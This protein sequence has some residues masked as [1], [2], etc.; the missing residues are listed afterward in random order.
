MVKHFNIDEMDFTYDKRKPI[1][2]RKDIDEKFRRKRLKYP[3]GERLQLDVNLFVES[4]DRLN[5]K[6]ESIFYRH[7]VIQTFDGYGHCERLRWKGLDGYVKEHNYSYLVFIFDRYF[8]KGW[9][10]LCRSWKHTSKHDVSSM[11]YYKFYQTYK[12]YMSNILKW[13]KIM[14]INRDD[15]KQFKRC[16]E[17]LRALDRCDW[18]IEANGED[19]LL[20]EEAICKYHYPLKL[21]VKK[22]IAQMFNSNVFDEGRSVPFFGPIDEVEKPERGWRVD[23]RPK[24]NK[25]FS[26]YDLFPTF[27]RL[28]ARVQ[29]EIWIVLAYINELHN[30]L[31]RDYLVG[32]IKKYYE[33][34]ILDPL[35]CLKAYNNHYVSTEHRGTNYSGKAQMFSGIWPS[36]FGPGDEDDLPII[37]EVG[38]MD[39]IKSVPA[40]VEEVKLVRQLAEEQVPKAVDQANRVN[41]FLDTVKS[42]FSKFSWSSVSEFISSG[43]DA[44]KNFCSEAFNK[45]KELCNK[46][47]NIIS[48]SWLAK[49][50]V[51]FGFGLLIAF[52][53]QKFASLTIDM[54]NMLDL[55]CEEWFGMPTCLE[56][57]AES[58]MVGTG[59]LVC[60]ILA[61]ISMVACGCRMPTDRLATS[62]MSH[63]NLVSAVSDA[64][65]A[66]INWICKKVLNI[67]YF[68][69]PEEI[70]EIT[71]WLHD[72]EEIFSIPNID[73]KVCTDKDIARKVIELQL[74]LKGWNQFLMNP[75]FSTYFN[76][77]A[78]AHKVIK[79]KLL[80]DKATV[81]CSGA[82]TRPVPTMIYLGGEG[83][84]GKSVL[85]NILLSYA[86]HRIAK[87]Y[88][89]D[90]PDN[91]DGP[92]LMK[93]VD[94]NY[95][96][97][98]PEDIYPRD[99]SGEVVYWENYH[100]QRVIMYNDIFKVAEQPK[101]AVIASELMAVTESTAY[102][103]NM[104]FERKGLVYCDSEWVLATSNFLDANN[105][106][107]TD[108][109]VGGFVRRVQFPL[110]VHRVENLKKDNSNLKTAWVFEVI[111]LAQKASGET[112]R[113]I[114]MALDE[115]GLKLGQKLNFFEVV[116]LMVECHRKHKAGEGIIKFE[117]F[118]WDAVDAAQAQMFKAKE[119]K[120]ARKKISINSYLGYL[121]FK[122]N[123]EAVKN[124]SIIP[125]LPIFQSVCSEFDPTLVTHPPSSDDFELLRLNYDEVYNAQVDLTIGN[126][127]NCNEYEIAVSILQG[128]VVCGKIDTFALSDFDGNVLCHAILNKIRDN[129]DRS[130]LFYNGLAFR[131]VNYRELG[132][133]LKGE[134][135][136]DFDKMGLIPYVDSYVKCVLVRCNGSL[137]RDSSLVID[138]GHT[139]FIKGNVNEDGEVIPYNRMEYLNNRYE[140]I[141]PVVT[142]EQSFI[143]GKTEVQYAPGRVLSET[144][145]SFRSFRDGLARYINDAWSYLTSIDLSKPFEADSVY[146]KVLKGA[147]GLAVITTLVGLI[148]YS[149]K[150]VYEKFFQ[151]KDVVEDEEYSYNG[152]PM[153]PVNPAS[154]AQSFVNKHV[155]VVP[156][157]GFRPF[158]IQAQ[159]GEESPQFQQECNEDLNIL[160]NVRFVEATTQEGEILS[161]HILL[162]D[163]RTAVITSHMYRTGNILSYRI[164][165]LGGKGGEV[166]TNKDFLVLPLEGDRD[167]VVMHLKNERIPFP[168]VN[169][170]GHRFMTSKVNNLGPVKRLMVGIVDK[171]D[172]TTKVLKQDVI[173]TCS[174]N[175]RAYWKDKP[176]VTETAKGLKTMMS[177]YY[178]VPKGRGYAG[179]CMFPFRSMEPKHQARPYFGFHVGQ[180]GEDSIVCPLYSQ[181]FVRPGE[182]EKALA[183]NFYINPEAKYFS[184]NWSE[185]FDGV[186]GFYRP[187][188]MVGMP[189][190]TSF[191]KSP[192]YDYLPECRNLTAPAVL[193]ATVKGDPY[194]VFQ[195]KYAKFPP[196]PC[197]DILYRLV[198]TEPDLLFR[199]I[200]CDDPYVYEELS[201]EQVFFGEPGFLDSMDGSTSSGFPDQGTEHAKRNSYFNCL[202]RWIDPQLIKEMNVRISLLKAGV[203]I[204]HVTVDCKKDEL[205]SHAKI[206]ALKTRVFN[207][208][209]IKDS[210]IAKKFFGH[211]ISTQKQRRS[212]SCIAIGVNPHD[213]SWD[214]IANT[215]F[216]YGRHRVIGGDLST[217]DIS[218]QRFM[219]NIILIYL[220]RRFHMKY[221]DELFNVIRGI[222]YAVFTTIHIAGN[223][224]Y[225][226]TKGNSSGNW[227]TS[228]INSICCAIYVKCCFYY[229]RPVGDEVTFEEVV[230][231]MCYGDDNEGSVSEIVDWFDNL[232]LEEDM[233]IL[234]GVEFT[235][236]SKMKMVSP[237]LSVDKQIFLARSFLR[238]DDG[239]WRAPLELSSLFGM[240]FW[241]RLSDEQTVMDTLQQNLEV[242]AREMA[243][244][245][246]S[247]AQA[248]W[249]QVSLAL[250]ET[251]IVYQGA[252]L[253]YWRKRVYD[254]RCQSHVRR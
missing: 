46:M 81:V 135:S 140:K 95:R 215:I 38:I 99:G 59:S 83:G 164:Y 225:Y 229:R 8:A 196:R 1:R 18:N 57:T 39:A 240:L 224:A 243:H 213:I 170:I 201:W 212:Q 188:K 219:A 208:D 178:M 185:P 122:S 244:Y 189:T 116:D 123:F 24:G 223:W 150:K 246:I 31:K 32:K 91:P 86:F 120:E 48:E 42:F 153:I 231:F 88:P 247:E 102:P 4:R 238:L 168:M 165:G 3:K 222:L 143:V 107:L 131:Y 203:A 133:V 197:P 78:W 136:F 70:P 17:Q 156:R 157:T 190:K 183:Q 92:K 62:T 14:L 11:Q 242:F 175:E 205:L 132:C 112:A 12:I 40:M 25:I 111:S 30:P 66:T 100:N 252:S 80:F 144:A 226:H 155:P 159:M 35:K 9:H 28:D 209:N 44:F 158:Y 105:L 151:S 68:I 45:I 124:D 7:R 82:F 193:A 126:D 184:D 96:K 141:I 230:A 56:V 85:Q 128:C 228:W 61:T 233:P 194:R 104:A 72:A 79:L 76:Q 67:D 174:V 210:A 239:C 101:K 237:F 97:F 220:C 236:P 6:Y 33:W 198:E 146:E 51:L 52:L 130:Y 173:Y 36:D 167:G 241:I 129:P 75:K 74:K 113:C 119:L 138:D 73:S 250:K 161:S 125:Y 145:W 227:L 89:V 139:L 109:S 41:D 253:D 15:Y 27:P 21:K 106:G 169:N 171:V 50:F 163:N 108:K 10:S 127:Y 207:V 137:G 47:F 191:V 103:V 117:D 211:Y 114:Q 118:D 154:Y 251:G 121:I 23:G 71:S 69:G 5:K 166:Y 77:N 60:G 58:Q 26:K 179:C 63:A 216:K 19:A 254:M 180:Y 90:D 84:Q 177:G 192:L 22:G 149:V 2:Q 53:V 43:Y 134:S 64:A 218:T 182:E 20:I 162:I 245:E 115:S 186:G 16:I 206:E 214:F 195:T 49:I 148:S 200:E 98:S 110:Q 235:D 152:I 94:E 176:R 54:V 248:L 34:W 172:K 29:A 13:M 142:G 199:G 93:A 187:S 202:S 147:A 249:N 65:P 234:F 232:T 55:L 160:N 181:D 37:K 217:M 221:G 204:E 87:K